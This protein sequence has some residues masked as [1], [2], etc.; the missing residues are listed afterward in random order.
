[1]KIKYPDRNK[2]FDRI[3]DPSS[4]NPNTIMPPYGKNEILSTK[5][6]SDIIDYLYTL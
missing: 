3:Y 5:E 2:L 4:I 1:M 6:I